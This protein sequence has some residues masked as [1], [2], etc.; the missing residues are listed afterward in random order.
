MDR[1]DDGHPSLSAIIARS[2]GDQPSN[3]AA[4]CA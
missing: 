1:A 3:K 2:D 4:T